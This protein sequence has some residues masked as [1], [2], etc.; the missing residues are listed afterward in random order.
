[1]LTGPASNKR[2]KASRALRTRVSSQATP[3]RRGYRC[4]ST[5]PRWLLDTATVHPLG[6][7]NT[8]KENHV[9]GLVNV[10]ISFCNS[11]N[12]WF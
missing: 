2:G 4:S 5:A 1:M 6:A 9:I 8:H 3:T 10:V 7:P 12:G 11:F